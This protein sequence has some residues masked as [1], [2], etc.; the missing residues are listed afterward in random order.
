[1]S[2][3][4]AFPGFILPNFGLLSLRRLSMKDFF[5]LYSHGFIGCRLCP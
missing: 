3:L 5:N 4:A 2:V 1:M